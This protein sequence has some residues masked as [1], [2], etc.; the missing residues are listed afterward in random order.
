[1]VADIP[2][3]HGAAYVE[4]HGGGHVG[5][6]FVLQHDAAHL[7]TVAVGDDYVVSGFDDVGDIGRCFF[8]HFQL[9]FSRC[10]LASFLEGVAAQG[11]DYPLHMVPL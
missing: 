9:G 6:R 3:A 4:G 5:G 7:G 2:L 10:R 8:D 11:D 1:M